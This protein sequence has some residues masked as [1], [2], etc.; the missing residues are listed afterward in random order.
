MD[1]AAHSVE[2]PEFQRP[3]IG[4]V[5]TSDNIDAIA[6]VTLRARNHDY[7]T[8]I[9]HEKGVNLDAL[10]IDDSFFV[11]VTIPDERPDSETT[12]QFL[13]IA[14]KAYDFPGLLFHRDPEEYIDYE[15]INQEHE[16]ATEYTVDTPKLKSIS[17]E[18]VATLVAIPA[19]NEALT[20]GAI[21]EATGQYADEVLVVDD[22]SDDRTAENAK[23]AGA[24]VIKHPTNR[25]YGSALKTVFKESNRR[26]TD[27]LIVID[28]DGQHDPNDVSKLL[29]EHEESDA[30]IVIGSRFTD[31]AET[32]L[33][34][35]RWVGVTIINVLTN[36]SM[37]VVR[38]RSWVRD[39]QCGFR[40]YGRRAIQT[41]AQDPELGD[42]MGASTDILHHAHANDYTIREVGTTVDYDVENASTRN[43]VTHGL[44]LVRNILKTVERERPITVF[45]IP[46][47]MSSTVGFGLGYWS[48]VSYLSTGVFQT[49]VSVAS[50]FF[51]VVGLLACFTAIILHSLSLHLQHLV[52]DTVEATDNRSERRT[53]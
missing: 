33:P 37:G 27:R 45:G 19:Y 6:R 18:P 34:L 41:L 30:D 23:R 35:Y 11:E 29:T 20:I 40:A 28:G 39:T 15:R 53:Q 51:T 24:T 10:G 22:G 49:T 13:E 4:V 48:I 46:G 43:P 47:A 42:G 2:H 50:V 21:V 32:D 3:A 5:A 36:L 14:A 17:R 12:R 16:P 9:A 25:G 26:K 31:E 8:I 38:P 44:D 7:A 52:P 1:S